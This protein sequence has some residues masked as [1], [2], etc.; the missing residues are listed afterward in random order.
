MDRTTGY[1]SVH[2]NDLLL[3]LIVTAVAISYNDPLSCCFAGASLHRHPKLSRFMIS[4]G[5]A[6]PPAGRELPSTLSFPRPS[7]GG[8]IL[9]SVYDEASQY[10]PHA[11]IV[12]GVL[13]KT[14]AWALPPEIR[15]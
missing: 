3:L 10:W 15:I 7:A 2:N 9:M 12:Q 11:G 14:S 5:A 13:G 1:F 6:E 8:I 4:P